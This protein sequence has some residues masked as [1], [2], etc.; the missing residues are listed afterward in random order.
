MSDELTE[1]LR[2]AGF[3]TVRVMQAGRYDH[4]VFNGVD[5]HGRV[6][7]EEI[8]AIEAMAL[9]AAKQ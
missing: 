4:P 3:S 7:G 5:G 6:I 9:E 2:H 1:M 8:N